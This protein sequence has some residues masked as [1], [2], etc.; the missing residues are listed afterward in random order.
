MEP[1]GAL[2]NSYLVQGTYWQSES[3]VQIRR[4]W[5]AVVASQVVVGIFLLAF[6]MYS[7]TKI[8]I[9]A[10]KN[11]PLAVLAALSSQ[12]RAEFGGT[13]TEEQ[14]EE[15]AQQTKACFIDSQFR[16]NKDNRPDSIV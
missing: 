11:S 10:L 3:Y 5:L 12:T 14:M 9:M 6:T 1:S 2:S 15:R 8:D 4:A 13:G 7:M 16:S